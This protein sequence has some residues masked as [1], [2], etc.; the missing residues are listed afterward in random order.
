MKTLKKIHLGT[1]FSQKQM[2]SLL[3]GANINKVSDCTCEGSTDSYSFCKDNTNYQSGCTCRGQESNTN[4]SIG[5][6]CF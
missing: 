1:E 5:C 4:H 3:G 6:L 2:T